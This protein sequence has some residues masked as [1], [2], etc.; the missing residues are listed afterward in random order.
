[1]KVINAI[2][3]DERFTPPAAAFAKLA[4][5]GTP[6]Y[7]LLARLREAVHA[8]PSTYGGPQYA[9]KQKQAYPDIQPLHLALSPPDAFARTL[10]QVRREGWTVA[11]SDP[12]RGRIEAT[13]RT[14]W[15]GF[16]DDVVLRITADG[17]GSRVDMRSKSRIGNGDR[18]V[19]AARIREFM[20]A[21]KAAA[22]Q[23][24]G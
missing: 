19:N 8:A 21:L 10:E 14:L 1:V 3:C 7:R 13:A 4:S 18:G 2:T 17:A 23:R 9:A 22:A 24:P 6:G 16:T 15:Y 12:V 20:G 5:D 11:M